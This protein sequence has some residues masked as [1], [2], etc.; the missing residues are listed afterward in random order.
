MKEEKKLVINPIKNLIGDVYI[1][2]SKSISNRAL[3]LSSLCYDHSTKLINILK[4]DDVNYMISI[5]K[6]LKV[7]INFNNEDIAIINSSKKLF[8]KEKKILYTG[9]AGTVMR[10]ILSYLSIYK[11]INIILTGDNRMKNRPIN[12]LVD[13]LRNGGAT[14]NY[15]EKNGFPP[16]QILGGYNGG[17]LFI[18]GSISSQ[19]LSSILMISPILK[20]D[21][22]IEIINNL[23]SKSYI[24]ITIKMMKDF[25]IE[26]VNYNYKKIYIKGNQKYISPKI[27]KIESDASSASYFVAGGAIKHNNN[28][29]IIGI[30]KNSIQGDIKFVKILKKIGANITINKKFINSK[31]NFNYL[32]SIDID[33]NN[34]PDSAMTLAIVCLCSNDKSV[35]KNIY[36]W[37]VKETDRIQA[38]ANELRKI[39]ANIKE[40]NDY[41]SITPPNK[42]KP[43]I[44]DTYNDHRIA[45]CF[46]LI[47][48]FNVKIIINNPNCVNKSFPNYFKLL[49][50][51]IVN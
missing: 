32:K 1:P 44:I 40:G 22:N 36:N 24:D 33:A 48:L 30:G 17:N 2:G 14:I 15:L 39:G 25:G 38:M 19:F 12:H 29:N 26:I 21:T 9:N 3:L 31:N 28:V 42:F 46:S 10:F 50:K 11:N 37:R 45:M 43:A 8:L 35:I 4:C 5:L 18:N 6:K 20:N 41:I 34:I 13:I 51:I 27:Y 23:V 7:N 47:P 49:N 16:L